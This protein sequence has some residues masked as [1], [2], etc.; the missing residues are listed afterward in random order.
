MRITPNEAREKMAAGIL[1]LDVRTADEYAQGHIPGA[2]NLPLDDLDRALTEYPDQTRP[3]IVYCR[4]GARSARAAA[5][6]AHAGYAAVYDL[7]GIL[8][9]PYETER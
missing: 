1:L 3:L 4:S 9:W 6:L 5:W 8:S 2:K 7:G